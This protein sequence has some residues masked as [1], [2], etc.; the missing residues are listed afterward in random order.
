L[1]ILCFT[2]ICSGIGSDLGFESA[3]TLSAAVKVAAATIKEGATNFGMN[4]VSYIGTAAKG[5]WGYC[6]RFLAAHPGVTKTVVAGAGA[7][8]V[9]TGAVIVVV[10]I[11]AG[12]YFGYRW[13]MHYRGTQ[14]A[15]RIAG[16]GAKIALD[17][18]E[19]KKRIAVEAA[20]FAREVMRRKI[21]IKE[22]AA[23][24]ARTI[25]LRDAKVRNGAIIAGVATVAAVGLGYAGYRL[26]RSIEYHRHQEIQEHD[27]LL[28]KQSLLSEI[29]SHARAE[30]GLYGLPQGCSRAAG[31]LLVLPR[32]REALDE[33]VGA[34]HLQPREQVHQ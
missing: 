11:A 28:A 4:T 24:V 12:G 7:A 31:A 19:C 34:F 22:E 21:Q 15:M 18:S 2:Q 23:A 29:D 3:V 27:L 32:G 5:I 10:P 26:Y 30:V 20:A 1:L 6:A 14:L 16:A 9:T 13:L 8:A 33:I 25:A 17:E